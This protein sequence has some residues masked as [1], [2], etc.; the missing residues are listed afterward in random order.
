MNVSMPNIAIM[1]ISGWRLKWVV[2]SFLWMALTFI[3]VVLSTDLSAVFSYKV[4]K[5]LVL[6]PVAVYFVYDLFI[7]FIKVSR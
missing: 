2:I 5:V 4:L 7:N 3:Y 6:P 1:P